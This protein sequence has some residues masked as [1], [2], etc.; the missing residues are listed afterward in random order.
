MMIMIEEWGNEW[1][2]ERMNEYTGKQEHI[3][4]SIK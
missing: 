3:T 4:E 2:K 1:K